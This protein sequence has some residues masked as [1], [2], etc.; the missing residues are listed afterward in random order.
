MRIMF[1]T[2]QS[3]P[4][5][6][7][8][9]AVS[10]VL[11]WSGSATSLVALPVLVLETTGS[12]SLTAVLAAVEAVPY[13]ALGLV[14]GA[15]GDRLPRRRTLVAAALAG[16]L[17]LATVPLAAHLGTVRVAHVLTVALLVGALNV[18]ADAAAFGSVATL[19]GPA[20]IARA[21]GVLTTAGT[22]VAVG[23]PAVGGLLLGWLD[24]ADV[25]WVEVA[26]YA[27]GA[28]LLRGL[29]LGGGHRP[30]GSSVV[31]AIREGLAWVLRQPL[32]RGLTLCG[33]GLSLTGGGVVGLQVVLAVDELGV[34]SDGARLGLLLAAGACGSAVAGVLVPTVRRRWRAGLVAT[35]GY[36]VG[37]ALVVALAVAPSWPLAA[38]ALAAWQL[39]ATTVIVNGIVARQLLA[40]EELQSR[41]NATARMIAWG[42]Q[43]VGALLAAAL[44]TVV[45]VRTALLALSTALL[46]SA[47]AARV[48]GLHRRAVAPA[49]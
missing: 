26:T 23:G 34:P 13:L 32:V 4:S 35:V 25:L 3:A 49:I 36:L 12:A 15:W 33:I 42:G 21:Q 43:P 7:R 9:F 16:A 48:T 19:V 37:F 10:R 47:A 46:A 45:D 24:P 29:D 5:P 31:G 30:E 27:G 44:V 2:V 38:L 40:P 18:F 17:L 41:V 20:G 22:L 14:A 39:V 28:A 8:R 1:N 11:V 6:F